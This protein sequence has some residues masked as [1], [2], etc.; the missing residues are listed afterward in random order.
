MN[1]GIAKPALKMST[2][3]P[4]AGGTGTQPAYQVIQA[5]A[6]PMVNAHHPNAEAL[7]GQLRDLFVQRAAEGDRYSNPEPRVRR[8]D[9]LFESRFDLFDW[10]EACVQKLKEFCFANLYRAIAELNGYDQAMLK[11]I[12]YACESWFHV[13]RKG[14]YFGAHNHPLHSWSGVYCVRHDGDDPDS[15]SGKLTFVAPNSASTMY[16]DVASVRFRR[17]F[18]S[19]PIML[20]L[21]PG[22]LVLFPS[23]LLHEVMPYDG[24][25]ER[26]TV[27]FNVRFQYTGT[28]TL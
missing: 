3:N 19:A 7:N 2:P 9:T 5:F 17:P 10:P 20:R 8:N 14:G 18:S 12:R 25:T 27:A 13:T 28:Q 4:S 1:V 26:I 6:V 24:E 23:W 15:D 11:D 22:Q 21:Q 16:V